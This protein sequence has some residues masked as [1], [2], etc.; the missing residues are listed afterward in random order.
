MIAFG[1]RAERVI[2][3]SVEQTHHAIAAAN[4]PER[5]DR[6]VAQKSIQIREPMLVGA[7]EVAVALED[8]LAGYRDPAE[9]RDVG[10]RS[11]EILLVAQRT[12]GRN[13]SDTRAGREHWWKVHHP[14]THVAS[15]SS[16]ENKSNKWH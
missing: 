6:I 13:Q 9:A 15:G 11:I 3:D 1:R 2:V 7:R 12:S 10:D 16:I 8:V 5:I 4:A 14:H